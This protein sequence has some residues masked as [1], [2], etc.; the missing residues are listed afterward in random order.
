MTE[1]THRSPDYL[2]S[3]FKA[4]GHMTRRRILRLLA[5]RPY[6]P[7]E[8]SK[9][10]GFTSRVI[11]KHLEVLEN[12]GLVE[13][14]AGETSLGP[15]RTYYRLRAGFGL[16]TTILPNSFIVHLRPQQHTITTIRTSVVMPKV[17]TDVAAV[18]LL[19][20]EL[21]QINTQ[22]RSLEERRLKLANQRG[23]VIRRIEDIMQECH[24][25]NESCKIVRKYINPIAVDDED[26]G[27]DPLEKVMDIFEKRLG[28]EKSDKEKSKQQVHIEFD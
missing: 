25:D 28:G 23:Q 9:A 22:M 4:L 6:Y 24:W 15:E 14:E 21:D 17:R 16:S 18:R 8:L 3:V 20:N 7:Y 5:Q 26:I 13:T 2:D 10:L 1:D 19:L 11:I 12:A 27:E